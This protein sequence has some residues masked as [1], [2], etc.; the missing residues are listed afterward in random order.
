MSDPTGSQDELLR[1]LI[2][3][4]QGI[5]RRVESITFLLAGWTAALFVAFVVYLVTR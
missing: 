3:E 4:V 2:R 1:G 5:R